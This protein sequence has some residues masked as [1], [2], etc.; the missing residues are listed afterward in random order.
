MDPA[1]SPHDLPRRLPR[2]VIVRLDATVAQ[3]VAVVA[4]IQACTIED[5]LIVAVDKYLT[6]V[7]VEDKYRAK[8]DESVARMKTMFSGLASEDARE[9]K[10]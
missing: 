8:L 2:V 1:L 9:R 4:A 6:A 3:Q 5:V 7:A 10:E